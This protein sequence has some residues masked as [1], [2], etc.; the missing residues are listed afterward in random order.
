MATTE[1]NVREC[2]DVGG[3]LRFAKTWDFQVPALINIWLCLILGT[4]QL[5]GE[6]SDFTWATCP[7]DPSL[8]YTIF[9]QIELSHPRAG[10][11]PMEGGVS[12]GQQHV[13]IRGIPAQP[14]LLYNIIHGI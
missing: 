5:D 9:K 14:G 7:S 11:S 4:S 2:V 8:L 1:W 3:S 13:D 10:I 12:R 6:F